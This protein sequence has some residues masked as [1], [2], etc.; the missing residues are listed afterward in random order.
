MKKIISLF[1]RDYE[2]TRLV[3]DEI[4]P[5]AEWVLADEDMATE[6]WDGTACLVRDGKLYKRYDAKKG[7]TPPVNF[8]PAQDTVYYCVICQCVVQYPTGGT[9]YAIQRPGSTEDISEQLLSA[10]DSQRPSI[11]G[12]VESI[13]ELSQTDLR[14]MPV[15][16]QR[17]Q[18]GEVL[19]SDL[20]NEM[21]MG[22]PRQASREVNNQTS[23]GSGRGEKAAQNESRIYPC[24][25]T[26]S[27]ECYIKQGLYPRAS[28][29][30]GG[31]FGKDTGVVG[32][33]TPQERDQVRQSTG[34]P[35]NSHTHDTSRCDYLST[36]SEG[37]R[38]ALIIGKALCG[39]PVTRCVPPDKNTG[40]WPGWVPVGDGS[41][42]KYHR[43]A[44]NLA[45]HALP[46]GTYELVGEN[47]QG[48]PY[49]MDECQLLRHGSEIIT[50][51][52]ERTFDGLKTWFKQHPEVEG[53]V[54]HH[55]D[56]RMV[57]VKA[58]DFG[59]P[60]PPRG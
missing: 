13:E 19:Q 17:T 30:Y 49:N 58:R 7:Q 20:L 2:G 59:L 12:T 27:P 11:S 4:V 10:A 57:K 23:C 31:V 26:E 51:E 42:D 34:K 25:G 15:L 37:I 48:N 40:H 45:G 53:I 60:W 50:P 1:K 55:P 54:W 8:E 14:A 22:K 29:C 41:D 16:I 46:N 52:P 9:I 24:V 39:A 28:D 36:L 56:G 3:Y 33:R 21:A 38:D 43:Q 32:A 47:I 6:K 35:V 5:G 18:G 44:W